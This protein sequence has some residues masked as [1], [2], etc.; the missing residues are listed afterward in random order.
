MLFI[1][2]SQIM[3][4]VERR[5]YGDKQKEKAGNHCICEKSSY[6]RGQ[7]NFHDIHA[8][9]SGSAD[10]GIVQTPEEESDPGSQKEHQA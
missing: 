10:S 9:N 6:K 8:T 7:F 3:D 4:R 2:L 5:Q 1:T